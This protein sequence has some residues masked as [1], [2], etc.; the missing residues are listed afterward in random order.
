MVEFYQQMQEAPIKA[1]ALRRAQ[2]AMLNGEVYI[3]NGMFTWSGGSIP[4]PSDLG[5]PETLDLSHPYYWSGFT[6]IGSPW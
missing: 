1:E 5:L 3:G 4:F 2:L 6:M